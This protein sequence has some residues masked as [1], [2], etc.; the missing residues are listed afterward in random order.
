VSLV[1]SSRLGS[2]PT[3]ELEQA[4]LPFL[5]FLE[6]PRVHYPGIELVID[7]EISAQDDPYLAEHALDGQ[8]LLPAVLGLEAMAQLTRALVGQ[9]AGPPVL[10]QVRFDRPVAPAGGST[11]LRLAGLRRADGSVR[12]AVRCAETGLEADHFQAVLRPG[13][14]APALSGLPEDLMLRVDDGEPDLPPSGVAELYDLLLFHQGRFRRVGGYPRLSATSCVVDI[15]PGSDEAGL[16][17]WFGRYLPQELLLGDPGARDAALHAIQACIPHA[18]VLPQAVQRVTLGR[19]DSTAR[20]RVVA[21]ERRRE[22]EVLVWD[23]AIYAL[24]EPGQPR[25]V[26]VWEGLSLKIIEP[27]APPGPW[28]I[29]FIGPVLERRMQELAPLCALEVALASMPEIDR[30]Q[31]GE[32]LLRRLLSD[33]TVLVRRPDGRPEAGGGSEP[34]CSRP[35]SLA[36]DGDLVLGVAGMSPVGC[37]LEQVVA[38]EPAIWQGLLGGAGRRLVDAI[39]AGR[40]EPFDAAATRVWAARECLVKVGADPGAPLAVD[41]INGDGWVMLRSGRRVIGTILAPVGRAGHLVAVAVLASE[42]DA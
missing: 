20:H 16:Q 7:A 30:S 26:E 33:G 6:T 23:L 13:A 37:D 12:A 31:R 25:L 28:P 4:D 1:V 36:H 14:G 9:D 2:Q 32:R 15:E 40:N 18:R 5:R 29:S 3:L 10:E 19:L 39:T 38:R 21:R 27:L 41:E 11:T 22:G 24:V 35:V 42:P 8:P 17:G 34:P